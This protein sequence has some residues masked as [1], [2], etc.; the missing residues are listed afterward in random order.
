MKADVLSLS[1]T[2]VYEFE[3]YRPIDRTT[4]GGFDVLQNLP[5]P[6]SSV[7]T[8]M[9]VSHKNTLHDENNEVGNGYFRD[10]SN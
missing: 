10:K 5:S 3:K 6:T 9:M 7:E 4:V 1:V 8:Q 2:F